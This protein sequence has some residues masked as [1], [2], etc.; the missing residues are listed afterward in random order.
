MAIRR[1][2]AKTRI[3][4]GHWINAVPQ[5]SKVLCGRPFLVTRD[6]TNNRVYYR[7]P[8]WDADEPDKYVMLDSVV[9]RCDTREESQ[10]MFELSELRD[11]DIAKAIDIIDAKF[12]QLIDE[13][14]GKGKKGADA[15]ESP[16]E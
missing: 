12:D 1:V 13:K 10:E 4:A 14:I 8:G 9:F 7:R 6:V 15:P 2:T 3:M 5:L 11:I 16:T